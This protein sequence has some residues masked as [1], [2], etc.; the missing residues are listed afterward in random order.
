MSIPFTIK[1]LPSRSANLGIIQLNNPSALNALTLDMVRSLN[2]ILPQW[3]SEKSLRATLMIGSNEC[4]RPAFCSGGDVR[5]VYDAGIQRTNGEKHGW[6]KKG[7]A[8]A[9]F[10][11]EEYTLNHRIATQST[12]K[13]QVSLWD[14]IVMGGGVGLSIH[15][16]YRIATENTLFAMPETGIGLFP[17]VGGM[18]WLSR[19]KGGLGKYIALTGCRLKA[20]DLLYAGIATHFVPS[21]KLE[22]LKAALVE[23]T[24]STEEGDCV[25]SV[26][27]SFH[28]KPS[29]SA[30]FLEKHRTNIDANFGK[31][32][33]SVEEIIE[34]LKSEGEN[35]FGQ[36]T[37][38]SLSKMSPTSLKVT[39][40]GVKRGATLSNIAEVLKMEY[41]MSQGFMRAA[42][43]DFYEGIRALLVD[44]DRNPK[45]NPAMLEE[46]T[47]DMVESFFQELGDENELILEEDEGTEGE[48]SKL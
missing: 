23:A 2:H 43:S 18:Y 29:L 10:F 28:E 39:L 14:G 42:N 30:S 8:T 1:L 24:D 4:R 46:V 40:E 27:M 6:G 45:W 3:Q 16:K 41:R 36:E 26:L 34:S 21:N 33:S 44:K 7:L 20:D 31:D 38:S 37:I 35:K 32:K 9:D 17:D 19:L 12:T 47:D 13:P 22:D 15:G 5:A 25:A 48:Q 11:R